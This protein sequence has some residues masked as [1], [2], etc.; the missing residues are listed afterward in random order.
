MPDGPEMSKRAV[1]AFLRGA[2]RVIEEES[3]S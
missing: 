1:L 2:I 3:Q